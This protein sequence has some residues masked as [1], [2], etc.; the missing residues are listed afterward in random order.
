M[1]PLS[2][3]FILASLLGGVPLV[4]QDMDS[5]P[6]GSVS[7]EDPAGVGDTALRRNAVGIGEPNPYL[8][9]VRP[10][11][12]PV[13]WGSF[14]VGV[15]G[16]SNRSP[17]FGPVY[18]PRLTGLTFAAAGGA[19]VGRHL[20]LGVDVLLFLWLGEDH[21]DGNVI[22]H[23]STIMVATRVYPFGPIGP[24]VKLGAG[25]AEYGL[26]DFGR[27]HFIALDPGFGYALGAGWEVPVRRGVTLAPMIEMQR[28]VLWGSNGRYHERM[29]HVGLVLTQSGHM[30]DFS[31]R[32]AKED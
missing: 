2:A 17:S 11:S 3:L 15:G 8:R 27:D 13:M 12:D 9:E 29:I 5:L 28:A 30:R 24:F 25:L 26:Y 10:G 32:D 18:S 1:R 22:E 23:L 19:R 21:Q 16:E 7:E 6:A 14:G 20:R 4:A 31:P